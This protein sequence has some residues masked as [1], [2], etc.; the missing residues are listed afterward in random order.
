MA[1]EVKVEKKNKLA[2]YLKGVR[3]EMKKVTW[4]T[5]KELFNYTVTVLVFSICFSILVYLLD[6]GIG[7]V[8]SLIL[9]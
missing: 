5:K 4:P 3:T 8:Y 1:N 9:K 2:S 6:L 7:Y